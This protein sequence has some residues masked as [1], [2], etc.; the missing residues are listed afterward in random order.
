ML[1]RRG[2]GYLGCG[3]LPA[4]P[5]LSLGVC[6]DINIHLPMHTRLLTY[7]IYVISNRGLSISMC[8][9]CMCAYVIVCV[10]ACMCAYEGTR[11]R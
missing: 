6:I 1:A 5:G 8:V 11:L 3:M 4:L 10:S 7:S 9:V 2:I